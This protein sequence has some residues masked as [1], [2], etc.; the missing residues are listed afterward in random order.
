MLDLVVLDSSIAFAIQMGQTRVEVVVPPE[1]TIVRWILLMEVARAAGVALLE[2]S[3][4]FEIQM[5]VARVEVLV[6]KVGRQEENQQVAP[7]SHNYY[8]K[9]PDLEVGFHS[10]DIT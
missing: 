6:G 8:K 1:Q 7:S 4:L 2:L 9:P 3:R 10:N 5:V